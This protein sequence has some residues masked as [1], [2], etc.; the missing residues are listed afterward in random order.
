MSVLAR[1]GSSPPL[2]TKINYILILYI[3]SLTTGFLFYLSLIDSISSTFIYIRNMESI[4]YFF[5][6]WCIWVTTE[7]IYT[8]A[9]KF[10]QTWNYSLQWESYIYMIPIYWLIPLLFEYSYSYIAPYH[11]LNRIVIITLV[12]YFIEYISW[13]LLEKVLWKCP[14]EYTT[15][16]HIHWYVRLDYLPLWLLFAISIEWL[17][18]YLWIV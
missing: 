13:Y 8:W 15:W 2:G 14:R 12:I 10:L 11:F 16:C 3:N 7:V 1:G 4:A 6:F 9:K 5:L 17:V 18:I